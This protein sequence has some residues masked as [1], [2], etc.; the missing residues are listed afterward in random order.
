MQPDEQL[1]AEA[2]NGLHQQQ[3]QQPFFQRVQSI[4]IV[5]NCVNQL[6]TAY[7]TTKNASGVIKY[8]A[9]NLENSIAYISKPVL[10][11][12]EPVLKPLDRFASNQ[13]DKVSGKGNRSTST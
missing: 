10:S 11:T 7:Q 13:L 8:S 4:P 12:L 2:L 1:A 5:N 3:Q 9:E 6:S